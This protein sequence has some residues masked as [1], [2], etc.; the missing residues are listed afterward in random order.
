MR[1]I[2][3][4]ASALRDEHE[5]AAPRERDGGLDAGE[6]GEGAGRHD[7]GVVA[8]GAFETP[9]EGGCVRPI[10]RWLTVLS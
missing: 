3:L 8:G 10:S 5:D 2:A 7:I 4:P 6:A 1:A 9:G